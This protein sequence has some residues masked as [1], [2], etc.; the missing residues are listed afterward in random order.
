M[1]YNIAY[2]QKDD[3]LQDTYFINY[4][5]NQESPYEHIPDGCSL[6]PWDDITFLVRFG[7]NYFWNEVENAVVDANG[8]PKYLIGDFYKGK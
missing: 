6:V 8:I 1:A 5:T 7:P 2:L 3:N 4:I